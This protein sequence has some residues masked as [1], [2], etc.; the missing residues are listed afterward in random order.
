MN[1]TRISRHLWI[2]GRVQ[3]VWYRGSM[4]EEGRRLGVSGWVRNLPDGRVEAA[5]SGPEIAVQALI[6]W[7]G[8]GPPNAVVSRVLVELEPQSLDGEFRQIADA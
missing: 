1:S 5:L 6:A 7:A 2:E 4:V 3:G 8:R